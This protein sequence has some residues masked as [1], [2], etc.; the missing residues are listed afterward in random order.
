MDSLSR[1]IIHRRAV[2]ATQAVRDLLY[3]LCPRSAWVRP[4]PLLSLL[5]HLSVLLAV[6]G[7]ASQRAYLRW[8]TRR[9]ATL[10]QEVPLQTAW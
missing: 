1:P 5:C 2:C 8:E 3:L 4:Y 9:Y 6:S 10:G 7:V